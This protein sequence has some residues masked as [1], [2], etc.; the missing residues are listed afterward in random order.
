MQTVVVFSSYKNNNFQLQFMLNGEEQKL[1]VGQDRGD[2]CVTA[3]PVDCT[4]LITMGRCEL[5]QRVVSHRQYASDVALAADTLPA[6]SEL[7]WLT[8]RG[9]LCKQY[10]EDWESKLSYFITDSPLPTHPSWQGAGTLHEQLNSRVFR[11]WVRTMRK[12]L[13]GAAADEPDEIV[14]FRRDLLAGANTA[15]SVSKRQV[16]CGGWAMHKGVINPDAQQAQMAERGALSMI[17]STDAAAIQNACERADAAEL[18]WS[19]ERESSVC[20]DARISQLTCVAAGLQTALQVTMQAHML[21]CNG[22]LTPTPRAEA[23]RR[24]NDG[25]TGTSYAQQLLT[26]TDGLVADAVAASGAECAQAVQSVKTALAGARETALA[27]LAV[28]RGGEGARS[29]AAMDAVS[30]AQYQRGIETA[31]RAAADTAAASTHAAPSDGSRVSVQQA[32]AAL[33]STDFGSANAL[34]VQQLGVLETVLAM[35]AGPS[36]AVPASFEVRSC[37]TESD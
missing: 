27:S 14:Q 8:E 7:L 5:C 24:L 28:A 12:G 25:T 16:A 15:S 34:I 18:R 6:P 9:E 4:D 29:A 19:D 35:Q 37:L 22:R 31:K 11:L 26:H 2:A 20:K 30:H 17:V 23:V 32:L 36:A 21:A 13:F 10:A 33:R 1:P 3:R